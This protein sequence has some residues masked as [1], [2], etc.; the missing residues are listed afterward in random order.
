MSNELYT[1]FADLEGNPYEV[2]K[3][4]D[5]TTLS[6]N[7]GWK[8]GA[9]ELFKANHGSYPQRENDPI[10]KKYE[11]ETFDEKMADYGL[12]QMAGFNYDLGEMVVDTYNIT[13]AEQKQKEAFIYLLD[14]YDEVNTSWHTAKQ[15]GWEVLSDVTNWIGLASFGT[16]TIASAGAKITGKAALRKAL[17]ESIEEG[18]EET[19][20]KSVLR[21]SAEKVGTVG[22]IEGALHAGVSDSQ[23]QTVRMDAGAQLEYDYGQTMGSAAVGSVFGFGAAVGFDALFS[24][25]SGKMLSKRVDEEVAKDADRIEANT[26]E[27][28]EIAERRAAKEKKEQAQTPAQREQELK[29]QEEIMKKVEAGRNPKVDPEDAST[30]IPKKRRYVKGIMELFKSPKVLIRAMRGDPDALAK[31]LVQWQK[32]SLNETEG[33]AASRTVYEALQTL[34]H[35][36]KRIVDILESTPNL[37]KETRD[38]LRAE[39]KDL[40]GDI[41]RMEGM[42]DHVAGWK[43]RYLQDIQNFLDYKRGDNGKLSPEARRKAYTEFYEKKMNRITQQFNKKMDEVL[44]ST[45]PNYNPEKAV[46]IMR[47]REAFRKKMMDAIIENDPSLSPNQLKEL[48]NK[49]GESLVEMSI[50]GRFSPQT[51]A[52]NTLFPFIKTMTYPIL[53][54]IMRHPL[55]REMWRR[56]AQQYM[57]MMANQKAALNAM[58]YAFRYEQTGLTQDPSRFLMG[59]IKTKGY[60]AA[61]WRSINRAMSATDAYM[62]ETAAMG[63]LVIKSFDSLL[64][65]GAKK[66]LKGKELQEFIN[67]RMPS[68]IDKG[69]SYL[70]DHNTLKPLIEKGQS[71]NLKGE[72]LEKFVLRELDDITKYVPSADDLAKFRLQGERLKLKGKKLQEYIDERVNNRKFRMTRTLKNKDSVEMV[73]DLLY[74]KEFSNDNAFERVAGGLES[75]QQKNWE[76]R[77][78]GNLFFRTLVRLF[79]ESMR[80]SPV[81]NSLLPSFQRDLQGLNGAQKQARAQTEGAISYAILTVVLSKWA[82]GEIQGSTNPNYHKTMEFERTDQA[83]PMTIDVFGGDRSYRWA[84]PFRIPLTTLTNTLDGIRRQQML[85]RED[86]ALEKAMGEELEESEKK[87]E[88]AANQALAIAFT[89]VLSV[90]KDSGMTQGLTDLVKGIAR[91]VK[92]GTDEQDGDAENALDVLGDFLTKKIMMPLP[93]TLT[94]AAKGAFGDDQ[95]IEPL[96]PR[97]R[98]ISQFNPNHP[99]VPRKYDFFGN[100]RKMDTPLIQLVPW[101]ASTEADRSGANKGLSY[102]QETVQNFVARLEAAGFGVF[103]RPKRTDELFKD[104]SG[105]IDLRTIYTTVQGTKITVMDAIRLRARDAYGQALAENLIKYVD[106]PYTP[107]SIQDADDKTG[108]IKIIKDER[109]KVLEVALLDVIA[110][111]PALDKLVKDKELLEYRRSQLPTYRI[112]K[113]R[114]K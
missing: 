105:L 31:T 58:R 100:P 32:Q 1:P 70:V 79:N 11:G 22:A 51:V 8:A 71:L 59:G 48:Y 104:K 9:A 41:I 69:Y 56:T 64:D 76:A 74:K 88:S 112:E 23:Q 73:K 75:F 111:D 7:T 34:N 28:A 16:G 39:L 65:Q 107:V 63:D 77:F 87:A 91:M 10:L 6:D 78:L 83:E 4:V 45:S 14:Q 109:R 49:F 67:A 98:F 96:T 13:R 43:G 44:D 60:F 42:Y 108:L 17:K 66:G 113:D 61:F 46:S 102:E 35:K 26:K 62:Q 40:D 29:N 110:A 38:S 85:E 36:Q 33:K 80:I 24:K 97:Q 57:Y 12:K 81:A 19:V 2:Q 103:N 5:W 94:K 25:M 95:L 18:A 27:A 50:A 86:Y 21:E 53:E 54:Q 84:D 99:S 72:A 92:A 90:F 114:T 30:V 20:K 89:S 68:E 101:A 55:K 37:T 47:Q 93:N 82:Q 52:V 3:E 15:A 106:N